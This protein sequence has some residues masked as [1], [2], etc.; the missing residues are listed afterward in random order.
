MVHSK[1]YKKTIPPKINETA[2]FLRMIDTIIESVVFNLQEN[3]CYIDVHCGLQ[4]AK[5]PQN[6]KNEM[7]VLISVE[8]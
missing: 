3:L 5:T 8:N 4:T 2:V 6:N 1:I 7:Y